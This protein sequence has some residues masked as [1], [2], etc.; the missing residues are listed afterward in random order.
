MKT[1]G[2]IIGPITPPKYGKP[3]AFKVTLAMVA[4]RAAND[5][6]E[7]WTRAAKVLPLWPQ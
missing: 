6:L 5:A 1:R 4:Q 2:A 7:V 3:N